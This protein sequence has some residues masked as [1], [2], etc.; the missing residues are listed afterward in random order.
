MP[1]SLRNISEWI[2][3]RKLICE[4]LSVIT[5]F[6]VFGVAFAAIVSTTV[7]PYCELLSC[8]GCLESNALDSCL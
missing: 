4:C 7:C 8:V 6:L 2:L 1:S 3:K 5:I